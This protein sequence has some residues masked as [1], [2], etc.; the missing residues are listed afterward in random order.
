MVT[1]NQNLDVLENINFSLNKG[2]FLG[3][4]GESGSGKTT[5]VDIILGIYKPSSGYIKVNNSN[6]HDDLQSWRSN[7]AYLPQDTFLIEGTIADNIAI[8]QSHEER[9]EENIISALSKAQIMNHI[10]SLPKGI[11]SEIG[12]AGLLLS[13][14]QK[15]RLAIARAFYNNKS[16]F[17]FDESTSA[18][19][20]E[21]EAR[22]L[23]QINE[24]SSEGATVIMISHNLESL[25]NCNKVIRITN[26]NIKIISG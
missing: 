22:I 11:F 13:G 2:D 25:K 1:N 12:D 19:D 6:I 26:K 20:I 4:Q 7:V 23:N 8:G 24:L 5:L 18:L 17:I 9:S 16:V 10:N 15:Q 14:G 21:S 3:I